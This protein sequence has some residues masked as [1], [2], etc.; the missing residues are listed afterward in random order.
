MK[1]GN[2]KKE[3]AKNNGPLKTG[4]CEMT[5]FFTS[6]KCK[7]RRDRKDEICRGCYMTK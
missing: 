7:K 2:E 6:E 1:N 3:P 4:N 5:P